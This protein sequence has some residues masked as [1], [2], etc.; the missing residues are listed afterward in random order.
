MIWKKKEK[1]TEDNLF[2]IFHKELPNWKIKIESFN[3]GAF[4]LNLYSKKNDVYI[5]IINSGLIGV[6][7]IYD[8]RWEDILAFS[9]SDVEFNDIYKAINYIKSKQLE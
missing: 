6:S 3:S 9:G 5:E 7:I 4:M 8:K 2:E 1:F